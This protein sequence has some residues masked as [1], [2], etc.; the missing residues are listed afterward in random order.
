MKIGF[1]GGTFDPPHKGHI[2][3]AKNAAAGLGLDLLLLIPTASP[4]HKALPEDTA[5]TSRRLEM[6]RLAAESISG[7]NAEVTD[8]EIRRG[9]KSYT[10]DTV[11]ELIE[12]YPGAELWL[13][14]G[15]DMFASLPNWYKS[16]WLTKNLNFAVFSRTDTDSGIKRLAEDYSR[17]YGMKAVFMEAEPTVISSTELR[18]MLKKGK[19]AEYLPLE[20]YSYIL[21]NRL[22]G[23]R[24]AP[25]ALLTLAQPWIGE[26]RLPHVLGCRDEAKRLAQRWGCDVSDAENAAILHDIT[27]KFDVNE[28]LLLCGKYDITFNNLSFPENSGS[29]GVLHALTGA[30]IAYKL[31]GISEEVRDAIRYHTTGR[32]GMSLLEKII[33]LADKTEPSRSYAA[34]AELRRL[35]CEDL[36]L[37]LIKSFEMNLD[38]IRNLGIEPDGAT[39]TALEYIK[40]AKEQTNK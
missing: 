11:R 31:F 33:Y 15:G 18:A 16:E 40:N 32:A 3:A 23:V 34:A 25:G 5:G 9:G 35:A 10:Y 19:G 22:Y 38:Y 20:V 12:I 2:H 26:R 28:Q 30:L 1:L 7:I 36:D 37:A 27:K 4:P 29:D 14:C 17:R 13:I 21:K 39:E 6:T 24:P 8:M